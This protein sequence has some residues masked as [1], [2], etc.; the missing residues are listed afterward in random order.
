[1]QRRHNSRRQSSER[2]FVQSPLIIR[3]VKLGL[4][5]YTHITQ[6]NAER[7]ALR[8]RIERTVVYRIAYW[9]NTLQVTGYI[10][11]P[12]RGESLPCVIYLR[13]GTGDFG[14][15]TEK[16]IVN[17]L[18]RLAERGFVVIAPQYPG[19]DGGE[20]EDG[21]GSADDL[22]SIKN[23]KK[24]LELLPQADTSHIGAW[25][26]SRGGLMAYMLLREVNWVRAA[27]ITG[28][29]TDE[30]RAGRERS[31]WRKH[32]INL[33]GSSRSE[34]LK[35]SPIKWVDELPT[36]APLLIMHGSADGRV[37]ADHSILMS[38]TLY[39]RSVPHRLI[40]FEGADHGLSERREEVEEQTL[41]WFQ[42]FLQKS[43]KLP[44]LKPHGK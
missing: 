23:L 41:R 5:G 21:W 43:R 4:R 29:P 42:R 27:V 28:A 24:I 12:K 13:G 32:Q 1:M 25:G 26:H 14:A 17:R 34:L 19:V 36:N 15:I 9:A 40:I 22:Q 33:Y 44:N 8:M 38:A 18:C 11:S 6:N 30:F 35:R 3:F 31:G 7:H 10:V 20:G 37:P 39:K 16:T 2:A